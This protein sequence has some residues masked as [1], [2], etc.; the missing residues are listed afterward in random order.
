VNAGTGADDYRGFLFIAP[1][2]RK[3]AQSFFHEGGVRADMGQQ[4]ILVP[5]QTD[6]A[7]AI[8]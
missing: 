7:D 4:A 5:L 2:N 1:G 6:F 8:D 3:V